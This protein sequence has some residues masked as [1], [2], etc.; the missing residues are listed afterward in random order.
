M[1]VFIHIANSFRFLFLHT[2]EY[3]FVTV[4]AIIQRTIY[5]A[6]GSGGG[7]GFLGDFQISLAILQHGSYFKPLG[8]RQQFIDCTQIFEETVTFLRDCRHN[9]AS[10][11]ESTASVLIFLFMIDTPFHSCNQYNAT[12][13]I[14]A[15]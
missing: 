15:Y 10:N 13:C 5:S 2:S 12:I 3:Q 8:Q 4:I 9:T 7:S 1:S 11:R 14:L 6:D